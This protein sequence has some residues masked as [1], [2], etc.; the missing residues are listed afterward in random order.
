MDGQGMSRFDIQR[1][2]ACPRYLAEAFLDRNGPGDYQSFSP[3][4]FR[5]QHPSSEVAIDFCTSLGTK[6]AASLVLSF[7]IIRRGHTTRLDSMSIQP[8]RTC[9]STPAERHHAGRR[10]TD[11]RLQSSQPAS[12][13][14]QRPWDVGRHHQSLVPGALVTFAS[15]HCSSEFTHA[16]VDC[17]AVR[18]SAWPFFWLETRWCR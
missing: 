2:M 7:F 8:N 11:D 12:L 4:F 16:F 17:S 14:H 3:A 1:H 5:V 9:A 15:N 10:R 6:Y 18:M 13:F